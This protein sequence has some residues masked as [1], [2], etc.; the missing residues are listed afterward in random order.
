MYT[1][2]CPFQTFVSIQIGRKGGKKLKLKY[3]SNLIAETLKPEL[4]LGKE[5]FIYSYFAV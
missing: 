3:D 5:I 4:N 2:T 1:K